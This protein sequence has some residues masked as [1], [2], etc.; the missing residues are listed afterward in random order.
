[1][2]YSFFGSQ[3]GCGIPGQPCDGSYPNAIVIGKGEVLYGATQFGGSGS[4]G[5]TSSTDPSG[6]GTVFSLTPPTAPGGVWTE[7]VLHSFTGGHGGQEPNSG[8][9]I[10]GNG[11]LYG[12]TLG[13]SGGGGGTAFKLK[14]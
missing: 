6:C 13:P 3:S 7:A 1:V 9:V 11:V 5:C 10:G 4:E 14:P 2:L 8:V 12:T